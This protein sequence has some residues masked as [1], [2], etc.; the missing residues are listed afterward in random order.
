M[1]FG[2]TLYTGIYYSHQIYKTKEE[3]QAKIDELDKG[4]CTCQ[5][6]LHRWAA[7]TEPAKMWKQDEAE[8]GETPLS[9]MIN[10]VQSDLDALEELLFEKSKLELLLCEWDNCHDQEG[11]P[12]PLP[13]GCNGEKSF[14]ESDF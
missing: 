5:Q 7:I 14:I 4:I 11:N 3:V 12:I 6:D 13:E 1:G 8:P 9:W 10:T 2:T